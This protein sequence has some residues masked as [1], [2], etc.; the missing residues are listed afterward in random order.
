VYLPGTKH[1]YTAIL[2]TDLLNKREIKMRPRIQYLQRLEG[3]AATQLTN[4]LSRRSRFVHSSAQRN[5]SLQSTPSTSSQM[6]PASSQPKPPPS[7]EATL[8]RLPTATVLRSYL[9][10][11][12]ST[13]P[14]LLNMCFALLHRMLVTKSYLLSAERN[15]LLAKILKSTF[16]VQYC[17]GENKQE[18]KKN[19]VPIRTE[20]GY[21][22]IMLEYA[23]EMLGEAGIPT[24]EETAR[25]IEIWR[26]GMLDT[27]EMANEGD[28]VGLK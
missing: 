28:F 23:L 27:V 12:I 3:F 4:T 13:S 16:Y 8:A 24:A 21:D 15:P 26:K 19:T 18:V 11:Q 14:A 7:S 6:L 25:E 20:L 17:I 22:G 10:G 9:I 1:N 2:W 5:V